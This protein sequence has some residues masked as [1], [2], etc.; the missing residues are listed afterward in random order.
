M[1][2][3]Q[4]TIDITFNSRLFDIYVKKAIEQEINNALSLCINPIQNRVRDEF[5]YAFLISPEY[6]SLNG[7]L[8][9]AEFGFI[10]GDEESRFLSPLLN[11]IINKIEVYVVPFRYDT[12]GEI[13]IDL[14]TFDVD[15]FINQPFATYVSRKKYIIQWLD[16]L[17]NRGNKIIIYTHKI[18]YENKDR[19]QKFSRS[20]QAIMVKQGTWKVPSEFAG[21][22]DRNWITETFRLIDNKILNII[23]EE[24][25]RN[26]S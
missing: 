24:F 12:G 22:V 14:A 21:T 18:D 5:K 10:K 7:G 3:I 4:G 11:W 1:I 16:W 26:L 20:K 9:A 17:I 6:K 25:C 13:N 23:K 15:D 8:L 2:Q 19:I